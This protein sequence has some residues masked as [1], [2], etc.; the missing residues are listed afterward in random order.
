MVLSNLRQQSQLLQRN[1]H[2]FHG[3]TQHCLGSTQIPCE[4]A[5][6]VQPTL[7]TNLQLLDYLMTW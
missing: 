2:V 4:T 6:Y 3:L 5:Q 1:Y 7:P